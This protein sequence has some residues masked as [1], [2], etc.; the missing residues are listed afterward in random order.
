MHALSMKLGSLKNDP[1]GAC[2]QLNTLS[3]PLAPLL[4]SH[5]VVYSPG[6]SSKIRGIRPNS[7]IRGIRARG[8][9]QISRAYDPGSLRATLRP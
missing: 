1:T 3:L 4:H 6:Y 2:T 9:R 5:I 8:Y 7:Y